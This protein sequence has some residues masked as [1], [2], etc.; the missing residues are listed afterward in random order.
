MI[1]FAIFLI[2]F[3]MNP[4]GFQTFGIVKVCFFLAVVGGFLGYMGIRCPAMAGRLLVG[5]PVAGG[6]N[7]WVLVFLLFWVLSFFLSVLF[8]LNPAQSLFG[9]YFYL[10]GALFYLFVAVHF[11][12]C[13]KIFS[14]KGMVDRFL[15]VVKWVGLGVA[16]YAIV[17][18]F[19]LDAEYLG[20]V[21]GTVGN[22]NFLAQFLIFPLFVVLF[23]KGRWKW[24]I[25]A[26]ILLAILMTG[27]RAVMLGILVS[28]YL[29]FLFYGKISKIWKL[30]FSVVLVGIVV[31]GL[32]LLDFDMRS[33]YSRL[34]LWGSIGDLVNLKDFVFG[35]GIET[36]ARRYVEVMPKEVFE[37]ENFFKIPRDMHNEVLHTFVERG[38]F[39]TI[40]YLIPIGFLIWN[41]FW[42]KV[43]A[44]VAMVGFALL[45]YVVSVQFS[46]STVVHYVFL[47]AFWAVFL[48]GVLGKGG[49]VFGFK[50]FVVRIFSGLILVCLSVFVLFSSFSL[51]RSDFLL[52]KGMDS[53]AAYD[54]SAFDV[55]EEAA[56]SSL[57]YAY[58]YELIVDFFGSEVALSRYG[59]IT[60]YDFM[61][62]VLAM[63]VAQLNQK[64]DKFLF[65][66]LRGVNDSPNYPVLYVNAGVFYHSIREC[67]KAIHKF[68][69]LESLAPDYEEGTEEYRLFIKHASG[70]EKAMGML[71]ECRAEVAE[72]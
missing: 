33:V 60:E 45:A 19:Y 56:D 37:Y 70:F 6:V 16:V 61:Y 13:W 65:Y 32:L 36:F 26:V 39:G 67:D 17:Q 54:Q 64:T 11:L 40:L 9:E 69:I 72:R 15:S 10:Q 12:I 5:P 8:S 27:S 29:W 22:P 21:Y 55:F 30:I 51:M 14:K 47:A 23:E 38:V 28:L 41:L 48:I 24:I 57:V 46:F 25:F 34:L 35:S 3:V 71:D 58:P 31:G 50:N 44:G 7:K 49:K 18:Y 62:N 1:Y 52:R 4:F 66:Y 53:Y 68:E 42:K 59:R 43:D 20:R 63:R 2:P